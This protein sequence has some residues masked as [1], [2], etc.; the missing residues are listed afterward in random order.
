MNNSNGALVDILRA[1]K[2]PSKF[3][4]IVGDIRADL[5]EI[6]I[7]IGNGIILDKDD[8]LFS[9]GILKDYVREYKIESTDAQ[10]SG[11]KLDL[12]GASDF[13]LT[14]VNLVTDSVGF[15]ATPRPI[16]SIPEGTVTQWS[17]KAT[18]FNLD[19]QD[20]K[21]TGIITLTDEIKTGDKVVLMATE[22][23]QLFYVLDRVVSF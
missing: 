21:S 3:G 11:N 20:F 6:K 18:D 1:L 22:S 5:P 17:A 4:L 14:G 13:S 16:N 2:N 23:N 15:S 8:L 10:M 7:D 19:S 12:T 9:A